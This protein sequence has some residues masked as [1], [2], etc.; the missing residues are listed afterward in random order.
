LVPLQNWQGLS[1][2]IALFAA[3]PTM[4]ISANTNRAPPTL[5]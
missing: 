2:F 4:T 1:L 3:V 5:L